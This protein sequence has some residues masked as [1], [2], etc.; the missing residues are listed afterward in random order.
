M[1]ALLSILVLQLSQQQVLPKVGYLMKSDLFFIFSYL[2]LLLLILYIIWVNN[3]FSSDRITQAR[4]NSKRFTM[5]YLP[6]ALLTY[7]FLMFW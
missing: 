3:H 6:T 4:I 7:L 5:I 2:F 1:T